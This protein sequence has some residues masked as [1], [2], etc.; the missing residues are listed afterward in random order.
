MPDFFGIF[1]AQLGESLPDVQGKMQVGLDSSGFDIRVV[2]FSRR[3]PCDTGP[4]CST[5]VGSDAIAAGQ[6][7]YESSL[8]GH[9]RENFGPGRLAI[10]MGGSCLY[11]ARYILD[12]R[13][14]AERLDITVNQL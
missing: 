12:G 1:D 5:I 7:K 3:A 6:M 13:S 2:H 11:A 10:E 8:P 9:L 14:S 4:T